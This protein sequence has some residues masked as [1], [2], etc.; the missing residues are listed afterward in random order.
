MAKITRE[1]TKK[2]IW[3]LWGKWIRRDQ[4]D[5]IRDAAIEFYA[6]LVQSEASIMLDGNFPRGSI[7]ET[8][9]GWIEEYERLHP[10]NNQFQKQPNL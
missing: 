1:E 2:Q 5:S 8:I 6:Y 9:H 10:D 3:W 4:N 7:S